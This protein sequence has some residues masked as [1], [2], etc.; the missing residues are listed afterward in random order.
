LKLTLTMKVKEHKAIIIDD[1]AL[2]RKALISLLREHP[3]IKVVAEAE[4]VSDAINMIELHN[5]DLLFLDIQMPGKSGFDLFNHVEFNGHIIFITAFDAFALRAFEINALDYLLKPV[6]PERLG[7]SLNRLESAPSSQPKNNKV[8]DYNDHLFILKG[9]QMVFL[10]ISTIVYIHAEG[11]YSM[12]FTSDDKHGMVN[13]SMK[14][15]EERLPRSYFCRI[16]RSSIINIEYVE[17]IEK[18]YNYEFSVRLRGITNPIIMS[19]RFARVLKD[20][21]G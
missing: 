4:C 1:E 7:I 11:D 8:L 13:K 19:R 21:M 2:A 16:H 20:R 18:E 10:R 17:K 15:W 9:S 5:P 3:N 12:I 6:S 14:E